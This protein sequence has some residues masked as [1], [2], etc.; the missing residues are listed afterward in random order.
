[1]LPFI[2]G[3]LAGILYNEVINKLGWKKA[4]LTSPLRLSAFALALFLTYETFGKEGLFYFFAGFML[5]G[6]TQLTFRSFTR[7]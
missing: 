7:R 2:I 4:V 3:V 1:M 6:F 5:G